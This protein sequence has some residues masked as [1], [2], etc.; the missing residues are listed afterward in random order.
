M[1]LDLRHEDVL[2]P[3]VA[4][5]AYGIAAEAVVNVARHSG[6]TS[7]TVSTSTGPEGLRVTVHDDGRGIDPQARAGVG[8][9]AMRERAP[10][11][12]GGRV[13][14]RSE[15]GGGTTVEAVLPEGVV[16]RA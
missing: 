14:V 10:E 16:T 9:S 4:A 1:R 2:G 8:S 7:C 12:Q 3:E 13:D 5:A 11:E 15:P 6:A